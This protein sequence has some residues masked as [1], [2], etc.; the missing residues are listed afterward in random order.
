MIKLF[1]E[2]TGVPVI[3]NTSF[4][5]QEL[6]VYSPKDAIVTFI[7]SEVDYLVIGNYIASREGLKTNVS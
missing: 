5:I 4:N 1:G 7:K 2:K 3:L 6:I